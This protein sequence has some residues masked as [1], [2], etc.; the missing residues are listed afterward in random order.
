MNEKEIAEERKERKKGEKC[1]GEKKGKETK[2]KSGEPAARNEL[3]VNQ[4]Y[5][6]YCSRYHYHLPNYYLQQVYIWTLPRL[7]YSMHRIVCQ[8][9]EITYVLYPSRVLVEVFPPRRDLIF[10]F[11]RDQSALGETLLVF[12]ETLLWSTRSNFC[13][14]WIGNVR[15]GIFKKRRVRIQKNTFYLRAKEKNRTS[16]LDSLF[17]NNSRTRHLRFLPFYRA[18][19]IIRRLNRLC[20]CYLL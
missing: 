20:L 8:N 3:E 18:I 13:I 11:F 2:K 15:N 14:S 9:S 17:L 5:R 1:N 16:N 4:T 12:F 10:D 19:P 7:S 6:S